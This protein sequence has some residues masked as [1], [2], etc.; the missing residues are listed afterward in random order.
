MK[1][2]SI[3]SLVAGIL[4]S[5]SVAYG[6][7]SARIKILNKAP[8]K[9]Q[10]F[11]L[12]DVRLLDGPFRDAML[13]D[14]QYLLSIDL[15]RLLHNFRVTAGLPSSAKPLGG[16]EAL[17]VE[18][19]QDSELRGHSTGHFLSAC[20]LMY[21]S[22]G[23]ERFKTR[24]QSVV[25]EL[26]KVQQAMPSRGF[27]TGYLSAYPEEFF[28]RVDKA[29]RVWA[30]Y[31]TL[32]KIMAGLLD[33]Y[34]HCDN[35]Q[36]LD[37]V[38][39]MADWVKFRVDRLSD[40]QQQ[41]ALNTE[42]GGMEEV[43]ANLY[44][45]TGNQEYL[46]VSRKFDHKRIFDPLAR[47]EDP[48][49][50]L[51]ANTQIPKAIG[52]ARD[53]ELTGEKRYYDVAM[54]FWQRVA[55]HRSYVIGGNSDG[56][57]FFPPEHFSKHLG[58]SSTETCNTYNMLKL[59]RHLFTWDLSVDRMDF[60]ERGLYNHI[61]ASQDPATGMMCY[62]VPLRPGAFKTFSKPEDSFWCC[63]GTGMENHA[64]Y[65]D[66][67]YFH[68]A[69]SLYVN[70][71]VP[72][73]LDWKEKGL[74]VRQETRFPEEDSTRLVLKPQKSVRLAIKIRYPLWAQSGI[75]LTV[76]GMK[77]AINAQPGSYVTI[78][79]EWKN[80]DTIDIRLPMSLRIEAMP[81]DP[82]MIA[83][84]YGPIVL[85]GDLGKEGLSKEVQYG[86]N[87]PPMNRVKAIQVPAFIGDV[88]DVLAR[89]KPVAGAPLTFRTEGLAR[90]QDATLRPF[91]RVFDARY[92][93]Y[94]KVYTEPEWEK[95]KA[96]IAAREARRKEIENRTVDFVTAGVAHSESEHNYQGERTNQGGRFREARNGW[97][98]Y[99]LK[100]SPAKP[101]T[102]ACTY[103]GSEGRLRAFDIL[104]DG[105]KVASQT[106]EIHPT[107][108]FD[109]E[110]PIPE[111]LTRG[112][113]RITVKFQAH[114]DAT[115]GAVIDV[116]VFQ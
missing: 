78:E 39:K 65:P 86:P 29:Q 90:P 104:V 19:T 103:R 30:P 45:V 27:N 88:K 87:A 32:H 100:I 14:Q 98:S 68:D 97:F 12:K 43:L 9:A 94:W 73:E 84:L 79:R 74:I 51:H 44:A 53:Y 37:V 64:K 70:L 59:T 28:D 15:D 13:R 52:A 10:A 35:K 109:F 72:S 113:Q 36:A 55:H 5:L 95:R 66:T 111:T 47:G 40:E 115:A 60:Y 16:W 75:T 6:Q 22:T 56:E 114:T 89:V 4:V 58:P 61:L 34:L 25:A 76:N 63:V 41:R 11:D 69:Q 91:Y 71:F 102:L 108:L 24:A 112:K 49:N 67:I 8:L 20:A 80:G 110:Y 107:E 57:A 1:H 83:V 3:I 92:T 7:D 116:R 96:E 2:R 26:A 93:V 21:S 31:Y 101:I 105:Q 33:V 38:T 77:Q 48:L 81:D 23:D 99:E 50:G 18:G 62:Y 17:G 106:L 85:A 46:R 42:F 54:F 82:R